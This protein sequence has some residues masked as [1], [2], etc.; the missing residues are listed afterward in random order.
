VASVS[1]GHRLLHPVWQVKDS[2]L[3][4]YTPTD[5]QSVPIGRSGNLPGYRAA[6][7]WPVGGKA[8][9]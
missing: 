5:L 3:R 4:R 7:V 2:N 1:A 8:K 6:G 9:E